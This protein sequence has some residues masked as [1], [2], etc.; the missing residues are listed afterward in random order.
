MLHI[1][2]LDALIDVPRSIRVDGLSPD[3]LITIESRTVRGNGIAWTSRVRMRAASDGTVDLGCDAPIEG[4]YEGVEPMGLCWLQVPET[5]GEREAFPADV[6]QTIVTTVTVTRDSGEQWEQDYTQRL[7]APG[8]TREDVRT[9]GLVGTVFHPSGEGP[10]P[11]I[12]ILN[13]SGGGINEPRGALW[14]SRG[15][16]AFALAYF[17]APGLS[18][19]ISNTPLEYFETGLKWLRRTQQP[20]RGFVA[21]T[22]QSRGGELAMLLGLSVSTWSMQ[23]WATCPV[24][25]LIVRR[26][27]AT[28]SLAAKATLGCIRDAASRTYGKTIVQRRGNRGTTARSPGDTRTQC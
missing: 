9:D 13:G 24:R 18:P 6:M 28:Q 12:M 25:S 22:G 15:F 17:K 26:M 14:A 20:L 16:T 1:Q 23:C 7:A 19:Y 3:E 11:A 27:P 4:S 21:V 8:V 2:P 5:E 10:H